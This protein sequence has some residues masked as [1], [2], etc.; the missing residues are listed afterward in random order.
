MAGARWR[1][2]LLPGLGRAGA[3]PSNFPLTSRQ[4]PGLLAGIFAISGGTLSAA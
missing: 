2:G 1:A 3:R 4:L